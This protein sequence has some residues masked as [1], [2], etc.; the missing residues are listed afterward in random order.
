MSL[1]TRRPVSRAA[2][3]TRGLVSVYRKRDVPFMAGSIAYAAFVSLIPLVALLVVAASVLGGEALRQTVVDLTAMHLTPSS[4]GVVSQ[5]LERARGSVRLSLVGLAAL[6]WTV[7][8]VFRSLDT[9]FSTLYD[10]ETN[11]G[12]VDRLIDGV[13]VLG[14]M[15]FAVLA[16]V[17]I[18]AIVA[19]APTVAPGVETPLP[20]IRIVGFAVLIVGLTVAFLPMYYVFPDVEMTVERALPG[21]VT[22]ALG[23]T[24]LQALFQVYVSATSAGELYGV[25]GGVVLFITWL[26]FGA[27]VVL[28]GAATNVVLSGRHR[29]PGYGASG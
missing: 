9:A 3:F 15:S 12:L 7:L 1:A 14:A 18:G 26:Y 27:V 21:A 19:V 23:W 13:V 20:L 24:L 2:S 25:V 6:L 17:G 4:Q 28:L 11:D 22:A 8:K 10:T 16:M 5:S 29:S